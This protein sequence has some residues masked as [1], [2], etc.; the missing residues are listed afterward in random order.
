MKERKIPMRKCVGCMESKPKPELIRIAGYEGEVTVD[1]TG[2]A[3]GRGAYICRDMQCL[4]MAIK[5][6]ALKRNLE[7]E[8]SAEQEEQLASQLEAILTEDGQ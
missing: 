1:T 5:K 2:R 4:K 3:K 6:H 7:M 8:M